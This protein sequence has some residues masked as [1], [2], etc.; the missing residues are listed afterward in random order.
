[1][2]AFYFTTRKP[3]INSDEVIVQL[4]AIPY[5]GV[6]ASA[7]AAKV[8]VVIA[9]RTERGNRAS[10]NRMEWAAN[11]LVDIADWECVE[12]PETV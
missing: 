5:F 9:T 8:L 12:A 11:H 3:Y 1:M 2:H 10:E 4:V 6:Q 7:A